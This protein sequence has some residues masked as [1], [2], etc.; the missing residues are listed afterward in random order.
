MARKPPKAWTRSPLA[1]LT[2]PVATPRLPGDR[3]RGYRPK[4][5][6]PKPKP[7]RVPPRAPT[8]PRKQTTVSRKP[9]RGSPLDVLTR[10]IPQSGSFQAQHMR[11]AAEAYTKDL[12]RRVQAAGRASEARGGFGASRPLKQGQVRGSTL[13]KDYG[14]RTASDLFREL[15]FLKLPSGEQG[16]QVTSK[17]RAKRM[18]QLAPAL[19]ALEKVGRP[20]RAVA[21]GVE[22]AIRHRD[23]SQAVGRGLSGKEHKTF[24]DVFRAAGWKP[25]GAL[26]KIVQ[27]AA[28]FSADVLA[29][30]TTYVTGGLSSVAASAARNTA[31]KAASRVATAEADRVFAEQIAK[32]A[33]RGAARRA[34]KAAGRREGSKTF[35]SV[36]EREVAKSTKSKARAP[37]VKFAGRRIGGRHQVRATSIP[38]RGAGRVSAR[39]ERSKAGPKYTEA[40]LRTRKALSELNAQIRPAGMTSE[41]FR[42]ARQIRRE[43]RA[44]VSAGTA[45]ARGRAGTIA[46]VVQPGEQRRV[47]TAIEAGEHR[48]LGG[49]EPIRLTRRQRRGATAEAVH[50]LTGPK[51]LQRVADVYREDVDAMHRALKE[52]GVPI[53]DVNRMLPPKKLTRRAQRLSDRLDEHRAQAAKLSA[54]ARKAANPERKAKLRARA[55]ALGRKATEVNQALRKVNEEIRV[56]LERRPA[57]YK[58]RVRA[59]VA[60]KRGPLT[61]EDVVDQPVRR[62]AGV[63]RKPPQAHRRM[64]RASLDVLRR[65]T[66]EERAYAE[67]FTED[68]ALE[69]Q[70]YLTGGHR[71]LA[72]AE[73]E[74]KLFA[75]GRPVQRGQTVDLSAGERIYHQAPG[76]AKLRE[77][78]HSSGAG[79]AEKSAIEAGKGQAGEYVVLPKAFHDFV[80]APDTEISNAWTRLMGGWKGWALKT[81]SYLVR[82]A[83]GDLFNAM[84]AQRPDR[85]AVNWL[86]GQRALS[87]RTKAAQGYEWFQNAASKQTGRKTVTLNGREFSYD[88]LAMLA[89]ATGAINAGRLAEAAAQAQK[90]LRPKGTRA[91]QAASD[92][93]ENSARMGTFIGALE[94][95]MTPEHAA[96]LVRDIHFD[97]GELTQVE[98]F[99]RSHLLPFYTFSARNIPLQAK[100][101]Y[102]RPGLAA[103]VESAR[104]EGIKQSG[105]PRDFWKGLD[106]YEAKQLGI[107]M[108]FG[109]QIYTVSTGSPIVDL[110]A[111]TPVNPKDPLSWAG[112]LVVGPGQRG[113]ELLG[114]FKVVGELLT[115]HSLFYGE[116]IKPDPRSGQPNM[117]P[118]HPLIAQMADTLGEGFRKR[119]GIERQLDKKTGKEVWS[120]GR[121][122]EAALTSALPGPLGAAYRTTRNTAG[123]R[124]FSPVTEALGSLAGVRAKPYDPVQAESTRLYNELNTKILPR[125]N[126]IHGAGHNLDYRPTRELLRLEARR[127]EIETRLDEIG[128]ATK[129]WYK[130]RPNPARTRTG[131]GLKT[132]GGLKTGGGG[133]KTGGGL[134]SSSSLL[135]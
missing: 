94:R 134:K 46:K 110:N 113:L 29:D 108:K 44:Q 83:T 130:G 98:K 14:A 66:P 55:Q 5:S 2:R 59:D 65:G 4:I 54:Q 53:G 25:K 64:Q 18:Q 101:L 30:P 12:E 119:F 20:G 39:V 114:P 33:S 63:K 89:E 15:Q 126:I 75:A 31:A 133:L 78:D 50:A 26:G 76:E 120:W 109:D 35:D 95:G 70:A 115:N 132:S 121:E 62:G 47:G 105:L 69:Y 43:R 106:P 92:R 71:A 103:S 61:L 123:P 38:R 118:V 51:R 32:G 100:L 73:S 128:R 16:K 23:I 52:A 93:V 8:R 45:R 19:W 58:P 21:G 85:L 37:E 9:F 127:K 88:Q 49:A 36:F 96:D 56:E 74:R 111:L 42:L 27:G 116:P 40:R 28:A 6:R 57:A 124:G 11:R 125:I 60:E 104:E 102:Q 87:A 67:K 72:Q 10:P 117:T 90:H 91:W 81:P 13:G 129:A 1:T 97:Y 68:P 112:Q 82:N 79:A 84:G 80:Q 131:G 86:R 41:E 99:M 24:T 77:V 22:A 107:P 48:L 122:K 34:A 135:R 3:R 7:R 17:V